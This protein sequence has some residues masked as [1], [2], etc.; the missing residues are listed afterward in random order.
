MGMAD[1]APL[2][3]LEKKYLDLVKTYTRALTQVRDL[4]ALERAASHATN[5]EVPQLDLAPVHKAPEPL[6][7]E[8]DT[9]LSVMTQRQ[10]I[11]HLL[12]TVSARMHL[13]DIFD[14]MKH[15]GHKVKSP[16][17]L[18]VT[19]SNDDHFQTFGGG[20]WG[21]AESKISNQPQ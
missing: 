12:K 10:A 15:H 14:E 2:L 19:L 7:L 21:L 6:A 4:I 13:K 16:R 8:R 17:S 18:A 3:T 20:I 11:T 1:I 5:E 9:S